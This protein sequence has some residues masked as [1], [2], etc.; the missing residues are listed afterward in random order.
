MSYDFTLAVLTVTLGAILVWQHI[1]LLSN[2]VWQQ[3]P[4]FINAPG[5]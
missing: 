1:P 5:H 2:N 4:V 3:N